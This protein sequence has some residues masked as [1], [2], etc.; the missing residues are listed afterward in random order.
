ML[1]EFPIRSQGNHA[2][3]RLQHPARQVQGSAGAARVQL[4]LRLRG[5]EQA[6]LLR[7]V[8]AHRQL[9][10][11]H[12][13]GLAPVCRKGR[14]SKSWKPC[15]T[16]CRRKCS[17]RPTPIRSAATRRTCAP[18]CARRMRLLK[19]AGYE[20]RDQKLVNVKT[21]EPLTVEILAQT[22][23][24]ERGAHHPVLQAL[25]RAARHHRQC[26]HAS[27]TSQYENRLR[28]WDFDIIIASWPQVAVAG[29]RAARLLGLAG[30]RHA[31]F[32]QL[33][34]HQEP[35]SRCADRAGDLRQGSRRTCR[36]HQGAR[37]RAAVEQLRRAA[38]HLWQE[39]ARRAG[40]AS[41]GPDPLPKYGRPAFPTVW[42][43]DAERAAKTGI[44]A[45]TDLARV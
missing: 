14:S 23:D 8:Q 15:A 36:R 17:P 16:R 44:A 9:F 20:V 19:E 13:A 3:L 24:P 5:D 34:R 30:R 27:T 1:E 12:R 43:W 6:D 39:R 25:A 29:Q 11:R 45:V 35:G 26:A 42:W 41:A 18:I 37:P 31:G 38:I 32:A 22:D 7:P 10:R 28:N 21:G 2:G 40:T 33:R 4:R